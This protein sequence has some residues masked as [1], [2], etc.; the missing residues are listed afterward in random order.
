MGDPFCVGHPYKDESLVLEVVYLVDYTM[1]DF[2]ICFFDWQE[3]GAVIQIYILP[4]AG[5]LKKMSRVEF[6]LS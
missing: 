6:K 4:G 1:F 3:G 2:L 5:H